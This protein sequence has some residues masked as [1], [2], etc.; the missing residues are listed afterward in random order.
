MTPSELYTQLELPQNL[1]RHMRRVA[2]VGEWIAQNFTESVN[3][4]VIVKTLLFHDLGNVLKFDFSAG[5]GLFDENERDQARWER[6]Q[7]EQAAKYG[8]DVHVAT[9]RMAEEAGAS[10]RVQYLVDGM[11][12]HHLKDAVENEDWEHRICCYSDFR[13]MPDGFTNLQDRFD[14]ILTRYTTRQIRPTSA[15]KIIRDRDWAFRL[16]QQLSSRVQ[17]PLAKLPTEQLEQRAQEL[18]EYKL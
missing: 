6:V 12:S 3:E 18:A 16:E 10:D 8:S 2:A 9:L 1:Q 15:Q 11:G 14:D 5:L 4:R 17:V 13:V 7:K